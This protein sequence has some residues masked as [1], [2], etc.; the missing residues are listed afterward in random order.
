MYAA[1]DGKDHHDQK[2]DQPSRDVK[3]VKSYE[4]VIGCPK[5]VRRDREAFFIDQ[6]MPFL[7]RAE[8][9]EAAKQECQK[10]QG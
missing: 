1:G 3:G 10:P 2:H 4:R 7:T 6:A 9:K 5:E 8:Q